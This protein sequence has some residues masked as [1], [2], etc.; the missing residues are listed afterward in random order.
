M[1]MQNKENNMSALTDYLAKQNRRRRPH[2]QQESH[3]QMVLVEW[4]QR[5]YQD[6][7]FTSALGGIKTSIG[8]A[9]KMKRLGYRKAWPDLFFAEPR[10]ILP[11]G[12][13]YG[14]FI[15]LKA[16][17]GR[18]TTD[19]VKMIEDLRER[20]YW[21]EI[22]ELEK[23]KNIIRLYFKTRESDLCATTPNVQTEA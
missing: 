10:Y 22:C 7:I 9:V 23:A 21:A 8:M 2:R 6:V 15:E 19:Q 12:L 3:D 18:V 4:I 17:G 1:F 11:V 20:G 16:K 14:L 13:V 5:N